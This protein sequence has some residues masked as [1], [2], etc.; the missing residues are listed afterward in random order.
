MRS[1]VHGPEPEKLREWKQKQ[2]HDA[3][4]NLNYGNLPS[5]EKNSIKTALL[6]VQ[7]YL[8]AYSL[9]KIEGIADCHIEHILPQAVQPESDLDYANMLACLPKDGGDR[10]QGFGAPEKAGTPVTLN[11]DFV[12]PHSAGC[13]ARFV[14]DANGGIAAAPGDLAA[15]GTI[16][17]LRLN[18]AMLTEL[19]RSAIVT[20]G[21]SLRGPQRRAVRPKSAAE[22]RRFAEA[23]M[24]FD[25]AGRLEPFCVALAQAARTYAD[26][27]EK[28][29]QRMRADHGSPN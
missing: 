26:K 10:T 18:A 13:E 12:S 17:L 6:R 1:I 23:V 9:Q 5:E 4:Q 7:G 8:C 19:R 20:H 14:Y 22:A 28:R 11:T 2:K 3:P 25:A 21:L 29:A 24:T 15:Q 27:E 16:D